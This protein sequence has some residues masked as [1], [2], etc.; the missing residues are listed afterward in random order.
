MKRKCQALFFRKLNARGKIF[1]EYEPLETAWIPISGKNYEYFYCLWVAGSFKGK[2]IGKELLEYAINDSKEKGKSG[3]CTLVSKKKKPFIGEKK[4]FEHYGF[5]VV[6]TI[7]DY[8]LLALQFDDSETPRFND[9]ARL[10]KID[11]KDFTIY[12]SPECPYVEYEVNELIEYA[13]ENN[14]K[15]LVAFN[16]RKTP[17]VQLAKKYIEEGAIGEILDFRGTYLQDW[18]ADPESPLSWRFQKN[19]CGSGALGDIGTHVVDMLR[20]L[21]GD[22]KK[23]NARTAT[24]IPERPVQSG[25][26]DSLGNARLNKDTPRKAV[27]VDDQCMFMIECENGAFGSIEATRNAWG[28]NNYITFEIHGTLG[29]L[30]FNYERRDELQVCFASDPDDRRGF[31]TIYTGPN[32]PYGNGL[33]PIPALGIGYTETKI[34]EC[35]DFFNAIANDTQ[36]SPNFEDGYEIELISDAIL[37]SAQTHTWVDVH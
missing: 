23:V 25:L 18:S 11:N 29:S 19:I 36:A 15:T 3:I 37:K 16:Y 34:V 27:D 2:G 20:F 33:W 35:Y 9:S 1:I 7:G 32:H 4:F 13:K 5:K 26:T 30:Y 8:E 14:I 22:F 28:R 6:D 10:M 17:A 24:Y 21:V 12:Y 31:R